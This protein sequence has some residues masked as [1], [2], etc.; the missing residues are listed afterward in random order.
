MLYH[1]FTPVSRIDI[2]K[3]KQAGYK[4]DFEDGKDAIRSTLA[5]YME[6]LEVQINQEK[7]I[8]QKDDKEVP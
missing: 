5:L 6:L 8:V 7:R 2:K 3:H 1:E 4:R